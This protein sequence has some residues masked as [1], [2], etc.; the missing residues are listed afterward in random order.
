MDLTKTVKRLFGGFPLSAFHDRHDQG[1]K[2]YQYNGIGEQ[3]TY[4]YV[5]HRRHPL[6]ESDETAKSVILVDILPYFI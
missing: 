5:C 6:L 1:R 4:R 3:I 2:S